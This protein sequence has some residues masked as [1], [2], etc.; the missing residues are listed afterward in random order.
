M[1]RVSVIVLVL[2]SAT[3]ITLTAALAQETSL[4][5]ATPS[6]TQ[7]N[8]EYVDDSIDKSLV[9]VPYFP[10]E[11]KNLCYCPSLYYEAWKVKAFQAMR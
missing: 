1:K 3:A 9:E 5:A 4:G 11:T 2:V 6:V 8:A 7:P 10:H